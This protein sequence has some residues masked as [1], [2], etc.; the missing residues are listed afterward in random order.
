MG[1]HRNYTKFAKSEYEAT[2][3][4]MVDI[5]TEE[6]EE[7]IDS[8]K[9]IRGIVTDCVK[10]NVRE[11]PCK[12]ASVVCTIDCLTDV[13]IVDEYDDGDEFYHIRT[14][15]GLEGFCMKKFIALQ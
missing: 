2:D 14:E 1:K 11:A 6:S 12:T 5:Y 10:L 3:E 8:K 9:P 15:S 7:A 13:M 4:N